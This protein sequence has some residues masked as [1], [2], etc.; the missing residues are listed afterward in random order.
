MNLWDTTM[1]PPNRLLPSD[2]APVLQCGSRSSSNFLAKLLGVDTSPFLWNTWFYFIRF[3][4][5]LRKSGIEHIL[6]SAVVAQ[7]VA[8]LLMVQ[9]TRVRFLQYV[10]FILITMSVMAMGTKHFIYF[11]LNLYLFSFFLYWYLRNWDHLVFQPVMTKIKLLLYNTFSECLI[12]N[13]TTSF[14]ILMQRFVYSSMMAEYHTKFV[15]VI[16]WKI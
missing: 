6:L 11:F 13:L 9:P 3:S 2:S 8:C 7:L 12:V 16:D 14:H 4:P 15:C 1:E 5:L 10:L